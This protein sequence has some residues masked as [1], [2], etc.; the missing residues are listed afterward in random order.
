[1]RKRLINGTPSALGLALAAILAGVGLSTC[2]AP[3]AKVAAPEQDSSVVTPS[4]GL[5]AY[6]AGRF[7]HAHGDTRTAADLLLV[8]AESDRDNTE[9]QQIAFTLQLAEGRLD[10][11][12]PLAERLLLI[13]EAAPLPT[14]LLGVRAAAAKDFA[15]AERRFAALPRKGLNA[16]LAPLLLA[17]TRQGQGDPDGALRLLEAGVAAPPF[18]PVFELHAGLIADLAGRSDEAERHFRAALQGQG[19][20]RAIEAAGA[21]FQRTGRPE[22]AR[23]IYARYHAEQPDRSLFDGDRKLA[24]GANLPRA[25]ETAGAGLAESLFDTA[26]LARQGGA[27][28]LTLVFSRL[29]LGM[30]A[31]FPL[32]QLLLADVLSRQG[33]LDE[34]EPIYHAINPASPAADYARLRLAVN[35][36]EAGRTDEAVAELRR[37]I[38][39]RPESYDAAMTLGDVLRTHKRFAEAADAY[40]LALRRAGAIV[41]GA[42]AGKSGA[43]GGPG[44]GSAAPSNQQ[45]WTL[46]YARGIA[47]ERSGQWPRAEADLLEALRLKPEQPDVMNYLGYSWVD[48]GTRLEEGRSLLERAVQLRPNEGA[49]VDSLGWALYRL[50]DQA[51]AVRYLER[52]A[53]LKPEDPTINEHLGDALWRVG[54]VAEARFQWRRALTLDPEPEMIEALK[55]KV[56]SGQLPPQTTK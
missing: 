22:A 49:I 35:F 18:A 12:A 47:L 3:P 24:Q 2:V 9:L 50:G 48:K 41:G 52:A 19:S 42:G 32:A 31:D 44:N 43:A 16:F 23:E 30:R 55:A 39:D 26:S 29:A 7:A 8:A 5:G 28:D 36:D 34:A 54:R 1:M 53:E 6:L 40:D 56:S 37:M 51:G 11:A 21:F 15:T 33:R 46:Y 14:M 20:L 4:S 27:N 45:L 25:V 10:A 38:A 17:W 13:D